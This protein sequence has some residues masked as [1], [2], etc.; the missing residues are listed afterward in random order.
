MKLSQL[1]K[2]RFLGAS[3]KVAADERAFVFIVVF[4]DPVKPTC[5]RSKDV[6]VAA[7][8][9]VEIHAMLI[10]ALLIARNEFKI[11]KM[12]PPM[13]QMSESYI[14]L[15]GQLLSKSIVPEHNTLT[16]N[17]VV[18]QRA[19]ESIFVHLALACPSKSR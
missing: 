15:K 1:M 13:F 16:L 10:C 14:V 8:P 3:D 18:G 19:I 5:F 4:P 2:I 11:R 12:T 9:R 6:R 7:G 17:R